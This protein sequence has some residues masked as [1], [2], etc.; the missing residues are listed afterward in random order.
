MAQ[1]YT[2]V[3][4][5]FAQHASRFVLCPSF[6][7]RHAQN[8]KTTR[9]TR[10]I[11]SLFA[12]SVAF[13]RMSIAY[14]TSRAVHIGSLMQDWSPGGGGPWLVHDGQKRAWKEIGLAPNRSPYPGARQA[15]LLK[16]HKNCIGALRPTSTPSTVQRK[17]RSSYENEMHGGQ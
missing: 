3:T 1:A 17:A 10:T 15:R 16:Y 14:A 12:L 5:V 9:S 4:A 2:Y 8:T 6:L 11:L 7:S 13:D